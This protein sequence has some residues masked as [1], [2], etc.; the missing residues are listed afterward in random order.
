MYFPELFRGSAVTTRH[1]LR[2][3]FGTRDT[4][5]AASSD[6]TGSSSLGSTRRCSTPRRRRRTRPATA[7]C[8]GWCRA[9]TASPAAS[10]A[11]CARPSAR[12]SAST[13]RRASTSRPAASPRHREVP[14]AVRHRRAALHRLRLVRRGVP[15]GRHPDGHGRAHAAVVRAR[16]RRIWDEKRLLRGPPVSYQYD[17]WLRRGSPSIPADK[18]EEMRARARPFPSVGTD[19]YAQTPGFSVRVL[20]QEARER[21]ERA[22]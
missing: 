21:A 7:A 16:A 15:E 17:P 8:T 13:S 1:F 6:R 18:L 19:E 9:R 20:A 14:D 11:T 10:P 5:P 4:N 12:R 2:N 22:K 3:L